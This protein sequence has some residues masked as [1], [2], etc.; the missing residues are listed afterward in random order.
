MPNSRAPLS[1]AIALVGLLTVLPAASPTSS[2]SLAALKRPVPLPDQTHL[3]NG[4]RVT[5]KVFSGAQ[6]QGDASFKALFDLGVRTIISVDGAKPDVEAARK[7]GIRYVHL[8]IGYDGVEPSQGKVIAKALDELPGP[9]YVH[10]HHGKHRSAAA[11]AVACIYNGTLAPSRSEEVLKTFGTGLNYTGLWKAAR[12]ARPLPPNI[13]RELKVDFPETA[14]IGELAES[15]VQIE[16][17]FDHVKLIQRA[18]WT[19]PA[20][21]PDLDGAHEMLVLQEH[22]TESA[23]LPSATTRPAKFQAMLGESRQAAQALAAILR[24][25]PIKNAAADRAFSRAGASCTSCHQAY[26]D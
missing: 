3:H 20:A 14:K 16:R 21:H 4:H 12:Q 6:P 24:T 10:C 13:L 11:V 7:Y 22:L 8:P 26:R 17:H 25:Q 1:T 23:R 15:M 9:I 2:T 19:V 18:G 5:D